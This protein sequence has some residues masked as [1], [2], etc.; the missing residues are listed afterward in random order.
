LANWLIFD[1]LMSDGS[2]VARLPSLPDRDDTIRHYEAATGRPAADVEYFEL[3]SAVRLAN[4]VCGLAPGLVAAGHV[5]AS[6]AD[7]NAGTQIMEAQIATMGLD[8]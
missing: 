6:F 2:G 7:D 1:R 4:V 8:L 3:F 5:P